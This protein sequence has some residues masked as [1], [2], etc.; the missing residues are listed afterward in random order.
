MTLAFEEPDYP[1]VVLRVRDALAT[2]KHVAD[3][4]FDAGY[5][6]DVRAVS[7]QYWTPYAIARRGA[8]LLVKDRATRVLDV[9]S[10]AGKFCIVGAATTGAR[11]YGVEHRSSLVRVARSAAEAFAVAGAEFI[12]APIQDV[13]WPAFDA[14]YLFN[15]FAEN[16]FGVDE[17]LDRTVELSR[18]RYVRD[19]CFVEKM[20]AMA[21]AG[22]RV[23]TYHGFGGTIPD[24]FQLL[25][26]ERVG[27]D[28]LE[29]WL[30]TR[31]FMGTRA[32]S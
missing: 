9:G 7:T 21:P 16:A 2:G 13:L 19:I 25:L 3:A 4:D 24:T 31:P 1:D 29:L 20:L 15:P 26:R 10:G 30:K 14:F 23:L 17:Q 28:A 22:T 12:A 8:E 32:R 27:S 6:P 5:P 18:A 11:F